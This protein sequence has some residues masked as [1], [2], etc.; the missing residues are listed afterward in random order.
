[1]RRILGPAG[2]KYELGYALPL[3]WPEEGVSNW[4]VPWTKR[5]S[6]HGQRPGWARLDGWPPRRVQI[7]STRPTLGSFVIRDV[8]LTWPALP[9][10]GTG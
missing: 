7:G 8:R 5:K 9:L 3:R 10:S 4:D 1:M 6:E 2:T